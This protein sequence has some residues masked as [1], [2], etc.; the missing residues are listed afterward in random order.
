MKLT[1]AEISS[2]PWLAALLTQPVLARLA[3]ANPTTLQPH[4][5]PVWFEWDGEAVWI[6]SFDSTRKMRDLEGNPR[7]S[8]AIDT[9]DDAEHIRGVV[10]EGTAE[11]ISDPAVVAL[12][13]TSIYVR[14]L[15]E[16]GAR[17]PDPASWIVDPENRI[18]R[19]APQRIYI[20]GEG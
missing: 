20:W 3:T 10:F 15:G 13:S 19:L 7:V 4:V 18:I 16:E 1:A 9:A 6:S 8:I 5:V 14:Y 11:V 12:R 2:R 17:K